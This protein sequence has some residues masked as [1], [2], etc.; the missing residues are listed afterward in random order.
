MASLVKHLPEVREAWVQSLGW[1]D[2]LEKERETHSSTLAWKIPWAE[3]PGWLY[4]P[5]G[6]KESDWATWI[7]ERNIYFAFLV[8]LPSPFV[9]SSIARAMPLYLYLCVAFYLYYCLTLK[10]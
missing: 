8:S 3:E 9:L 2:P 4:S 7:N 1:E 6:H 5:W 10:K